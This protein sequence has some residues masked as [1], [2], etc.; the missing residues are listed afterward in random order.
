MY[1]NRTLWLP[2]IDHAGIATQML[3]ERQL[4][5]EGTSR[6]EVGREKFLE[7]VW[8]WKDEKGGAIVQQLR[9]IGASCDWSRQQFTLNEHMSGAVIEAFI[10]L[11]EK[12][13]ISKGQ[14]MVNW[15][16]VLQTA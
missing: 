4:V 9:R 6:K 1:G 5:S 15:S 8:E 12:G 2:G 16:P 7:R 13:M 14:R 11:H 3:V 10:R